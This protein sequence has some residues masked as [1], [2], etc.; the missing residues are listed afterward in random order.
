MPP[1]RR[2]PRM[3]SRKRSGMP[4]A[5][6]ICSP[7]TG[8]SL[9]SAAASSTAALVAARVAQGVGAALLLPGTLAII[10]QTFDEEG[11]QARAIGIWAAL[12]SAALPA[13][14]LLG[15]ALVET[16]GWRAIFFLNIPI[17]VAA[18]IT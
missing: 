12:G 5:V 17:V 1:L 7:F 4:W 18:G 3:F 6:A 2:S 10:A 9:S 15:G 13:G 8:V 11:E 16:S 14:P